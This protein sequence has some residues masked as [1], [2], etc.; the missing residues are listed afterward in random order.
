MNT[1]FKFQWSQTTFI[2]NSLHRGGR[3]TV[4]SLM[5][6]IELL[7]ELTSSAHPTLGPIFTSDLHW[8]L[9]ASSFI[10]HYFIFIT[11]ADFF[12]VI[13][14]SALLFRP[15]NLL[16]HQ[17]FGFILHTILLVSLCTTSLWMLSTTQSV[18]FLRPR[19]PQLSKPFCP[20]FS[21]FFNFYIKYTFNFTTC[22]VY[23]EYAKI[24]GVLQV[25]FW[26]LL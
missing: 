3:N 18:L 16:N 26:Y 5:R 11:L 8:S 1:I 4:N 21:F 19:R 6:L 12:C 20:L 17:E 10:K 25:Y 23:F 13:F 9:T 7:P 15:W 2:R 22:S 24:F 14:V